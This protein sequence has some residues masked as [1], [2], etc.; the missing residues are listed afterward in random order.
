LVI[1]TFDNYLYINLMLDIMPLVPFHF[2]YNYIL[3]YFLPFTNPF[4]IYDLVIY[5]DL[6]DYDFQLEIKILL[7][8][9]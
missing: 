6:I 5:E 3:N 9:I 8:F 7:I 2:A 1:I 4:M